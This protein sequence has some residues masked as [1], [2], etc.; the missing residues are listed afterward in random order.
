MAG[1]ARGVDT[2][3][4]VLPTRE[5]RHGSAWTPE[6]R[7]NLKNA[8]FQRDADPLDPTCDCYTCQTFSRAYLRHLV[9]ADELLGLRLLTIHNLAF[10]LRLMRE[11]RAAILDG[12][13]ASWRADWEAR[14]PRALPGLA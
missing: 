10:L 2:F 5:A 1:A 4:C 7:L 9:K 13:F 12:C 6:G 8:R 3:D 14:W 11:V